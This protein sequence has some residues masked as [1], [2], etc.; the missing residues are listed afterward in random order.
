MGDVI[1]F[2][3]R[4]VPNAIKVV[5]DFGEW[6]IGYYKDQ[7]FISWQSFHSK[8]SA[9][10]EAIRF[11]KEGLIWKFGD[12][13]LVY[14]MADGTDGGCWAVA[15]ESQSGSSDALLG[16]YFVIDL[17][18]DSAIIAARDAKAGVSLAVCG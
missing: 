7:R 18:I 15:H 9:E 3:G 4:N 1:R 14:I 11:A 13:G 2:P 16:R 12:N 8:A 5:L 17:A 6:K 10:E